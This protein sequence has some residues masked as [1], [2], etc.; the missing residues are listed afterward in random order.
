[1]IKKSAIALAVTAAAWGLTGCGETEVATAEGVLL[2]AEIEGVSYKSGALS[3][4]TGADGKFKYE[5]GQPVSFS[6]D[7]VTLGTVEG[8][9]FVTP[10][11]LTGDTS[12]GGAGALAMAQWLQSLDADANPENG[13]KVDKTRMAA[14][15]KAPQSWA[16]ADDNAIK[17]LLANADHFVP[18]AKAW[19]HFQTQ[20]ALKK[21]VPEMTLVGRL[22]GDALAG[23]S[24]AEIIAF[25]KPSKSSFHIVAGSSLVERLDLA[26][27]GTTALAN[28]TTAQNLS[29]ASTISVG[30]DVST[31]GF[32]AG[33]VQSVAIAGDLMAV[34]VQATP[35]TDPG[36]VALYRIAANGAASFLRSVAVGAQP[37][38]VTFSP[39][40]LTL[41]AANEGELSDT[42]STDGVDPEGSISVVKLN[43]SGA[44]LSATTLDFK[45]FNVGGARAAEL[46]AEVRIG[47]AGA[48]VAQDLEPEYVS[49]SPDGKQAFVTLQENNAV[50]VVDLSNVSITKIVSL[51]FKDHGLKR[52]AF[53]P[54]DKVKA[55]VTSNPLS[56]LKTY[57]N[58]YGMRSPDGIASFTHQG[59][60]YFVTANEGDDRNDFLATAEAVRVATLSLDATAFPDA[61]V[62]AEL[63]RL[64]VMATDAKGKFGDTDGDGD[65]DKLFVLGAR[66]FSVFEA[67]SGELVFDSGDD[68]ERLVYLDALNSG[69]AA[70][71]LLG[72]AGIN[73]RLDNK[74]PE[75]ETVVMG[76]VRGKPYLF[77]A[78]ER[79]SGIMMLDM[80]NPR[81]PKVVRY[82]RNT[83]SRLPA[84][85]DFVASDGDISPEGLKFISADDSPTGKALLLAGYEVSGTVTV[86]QID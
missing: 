3:G 37:D 67:E 17:A 59:K 78:L 73:D 19:K 52:N 4:V 11:E 77:V 84:L 83:G 28:P 76:E 22:A 44:V 81:Q 36:V 25:H 27:L 53:A 42:F 41:V 13:I 65:Y 5:V 16:N 7:G 70:S 54:S 82:F 47:R 9:S 64:T 55:T 31:G 72:S 51:G 15:A 21:G 14:G 10:I 86:I 26:N 60:T 80:E 24:R 68:I 33:G 18:S 35:K 74:G 23:A 29:V 1:M 30:T 43:A 50:A 48:K 12:A 38:S 45:E 40:G 46:P 2:D 39:D 71:T 32:V 61:A 62:K 75:P 34:A 69:D 49:V 66:S 8:A 79:A 6:I 85:E 58:V 20:Q 63:A 56:T 57:A